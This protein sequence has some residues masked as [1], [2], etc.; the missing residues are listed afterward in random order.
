[1]AAVGDRPK[2]LDESK[3]WLLER[4]RTNRSPM[5]FAEEAAAQ[6]AIARLQS[7]DWEHWASVWGETAARFE[8]AAQAAEARDDAGAA[9]K[10][11]F[12]AY[13]F[14]SLGRYPCP[15]HPRKQECAVKGRESYLRAARGFDPP[16]EHIAI[17]FAGAPHEGREM[18]VH[19]RKPKG[20]A[21]PPVMVM[22]GGVDSYKEE[23]YDVS[24]Q[25]LAA[26]TATVA[27][28]MPGTG[29]S[30]VLGSPTGERQYTA[31][32]D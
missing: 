3:E 21:R 13:V 6:A 16:L 15:N 10:A 20:A 14:Y 2:T 24:N 31:V 22:H 29:E 4:L 7:M 18:V 27:I 30:P 23:R 5:V 32:F 8:Q 17:P 26:G 19:L 1:M 11:Y 28:D 25:F 12:Q 9:A